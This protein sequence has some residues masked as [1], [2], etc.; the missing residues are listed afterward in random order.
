MHFV[1]LINAL[2]LGFDN[3][4]CKECLNPEDDSVYIILFKLFFNSA[5]SLVLLS[6]VF[7]MN[8]LKSS[9]IDPGPAIINT[10][11]FSKLICFIN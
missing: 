9:L 6:I 10:L 3:I 11:V 7:S 8:F 1:S 4:S 2:I 5:H